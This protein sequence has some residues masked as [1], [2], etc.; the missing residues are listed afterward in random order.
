M[1]YDFFGIEIA[2]IILD[3]YDQWFYH[4]R[5]LKLKKAKHLKR[6]DAKPLAYVPSREYGSR[7]AGQIH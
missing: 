6:C 5:Y 7:V 1:K 4:K 2:P 3:R